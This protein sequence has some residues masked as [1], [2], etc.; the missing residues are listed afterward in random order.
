L[1]EVVEVSLV[2]FKAQNHG[3]QVGKR[4]ARD[5]VDDRGTPP[6][7]FDPLMGRFGFTLDV[8]AA[9]HNAKC[10]RWFGVEAN[11]LEQPWTGR[12]WCNPPYSNLGA[13]VQK[14]WDEWRVGGRPELIVMLLPANRPEQD[15]WQDH[16]EHD[17]DQDGSPLT[18][19]FLRGRRRFIM[20][21]QTEVLPN[22]RPP[23]GVCLAIWG[24]R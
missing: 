11:G 6:E 22:Q 16:I 3:Q 1:V 21:G 4:G 18:I 10:P 5:A 20:P 24:R 15:W 14:A 12:V 9:A 2:G 8:A 19:E 13:W 7:L 17:R 23:F